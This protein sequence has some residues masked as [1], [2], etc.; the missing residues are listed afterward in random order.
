MA[1]WIERLPIGT[2]ISA[3]VVCR[4]G[5][6]QLMEMTKVRRDTLEVLSPRQQ[7]C[8]GCG[9]GVVEVQIQIEGLC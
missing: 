5:F 6:R 7:A 9:A 3:P 1:G 4:C 8:P 2:H